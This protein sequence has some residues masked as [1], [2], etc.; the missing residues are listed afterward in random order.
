MFRCALRRGVDRGLLRE[1]TVF[2]AG[3]DTLQDVSGW[4]D[5]CPLAAQEVARC[6][7]DVDEAFE[8]KKD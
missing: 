3:D 5:L 7:E 4:S 8:A 2:S 6:V 1:A